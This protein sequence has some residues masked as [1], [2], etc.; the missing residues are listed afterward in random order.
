MFNSTLEIII[1]ARDEASQVMSGLNSKLK[2]MEPT[3]KK[4][5]AVG[6]VA[7]GAIAAVA[8][9]ALKESAAAAADM[10]IA[11]TTLENSLRSLSGVSLKNL[12]TQAGGASNSLKFLK[13]SMEGAS[14]A[15]L[16]LGFDDESAAKS[17]ARLFQVTKD[18]TQSHKDLQI[19]MDMARAKNI[20]LEDATQKL[21]MVH[22]GKTKA[23]QQEGFAI[24]ENASALDN[25]NTLSKTFAGQAT[26]YATTMTGQFD[27]LKER[28]NNV[29]QAVGDSL[30]VEFE[31]AFTAIQPFLNKI[32]E[33]V[34]KNPDL[35]AKILLVSGAIAGITA[36]AG[37]L[38]L[39]L[40]FLTSPIG[41]VALA[42][43]GLI[44]LAVLIV[45]KWG[46]IK[47]FFTTLWTNIKNTFK[48]AIDGIV[49]FFD[50]LVQVVEKVM[51]TIE[52]IGSGIKNV[53][54]SVGAKVSDI[55]SG[56]KAQGGNVS[57]G[58]SYIVGERGPE[59]FT[60]GSGGYI[61]PTNRLG[62]G[63]NTTIVNI[64]GGQYLSQEAALDM[65][66]KILRAL[67]VQMRGA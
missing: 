59:V 29:K 24:D 42:I 26:N 35:V 28:I 16:K 21:I 58:S 46:S 57:G 1:K 56:G 66:D 32:M 27:I 65:G 55:F 4:M 53:A 23:L 34:E 38:G 10:S 20:S 48:S 61:T 7:F 54:K 41:L 47:E 67:Q 3:F 2:G 37:A 14:Q 13:T 25:L 30:K 62:G 49:S 44:A 15:A 60:P 64:N 9:S 39:A 63:G 40:L 50:P 52:R 51:R 45:A 11:N 17:Y 12:E 18:V 8:V 43:T 22:M 36:V 19:A 6:T 33:W 31:K 5:A